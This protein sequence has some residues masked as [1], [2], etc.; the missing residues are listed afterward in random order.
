MTPLEEKFKRIAEENGWWF[1]LYDG[2]TFVARLSE[3][4]RQLGYPFRVSGTLVDQSLEDGIISND[5]GSGVEQF[6]AGM[7]YIISVMENVHNPLKYKQF[8]LQYLE[9]YPN[10]R[11]EKV[12]SEKTGVS[13]RQIR[14]ARMCGFADPYVLDL[15]CTKL[16][17]ISPGLLYG[18]DAWAAGVDTSFTDE[19]VEEWLV[20]GRSG[21]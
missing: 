12:M 3:A 1:S 5:Y 17:G 14:R 4:D 20:E 21:L 10:D 8:Y 6:K 9:A 7:R 2:G 15:L 19:D 11:S 13:E 16:L 18:F